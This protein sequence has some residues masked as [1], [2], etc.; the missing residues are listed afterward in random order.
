MG[1]EFSLLASLGYGLHVDRRFG[2]DGTQ[3]P[4]LGLDL[5]APWILKDQHLDISASPLRLDLY[6]EV[7]SGSLYLYPECE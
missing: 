5:E 2:M 3:I 6:V 1:M 7:Y 4:T